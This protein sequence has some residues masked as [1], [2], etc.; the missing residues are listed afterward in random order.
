[1]SK[2]NLLK[3]QRLHYK[4]LTDKFRSYTNRFNEKFTELKACYHTTNIDEILKMRDSYNIQLQSKKNFYKDKVY[5]LKEK[6][7]WLRMLQRELNEITITH[8]ANKELQNSLNKFDSR[9]SIKGLPIID[10]LYYRKIMNEATIKLEKKQTL[11]RKIADEIIHIGYVLRDYADYGNSGDWHKLNLIS[12][13]GASSTNEITF[14]FSQLLLA[15][16]QRITTVNF[17]ILQRINHMDIMK[18]ID[19]D[20]VDLE[21][22]DI[23]ILESDN[24]FSF[25]II[26]E[27]HFRAQQNEPVVL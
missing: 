12:L 21:Y 2:I 3:K 8:K 6:M 18:D 10:Y 9:E 19:L 22:S 25:S 7:D 23:I 26:S 24:S 4:A 13:I 1:M 16:E 15:L 20:S 14:K 17:I 11:L 27:M 5:I